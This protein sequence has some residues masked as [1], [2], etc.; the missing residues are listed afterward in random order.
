MKSF[1][2]SFLLQLRRPSDATKSMFCTGFVHSIIVTKY[3]LETLGL[4]Q[5]VFTRR[6]SANNVIEAFKHLQTHDCRSST[7]PC[8]DVVWLFSI[9]DRVV[10]I[11][12]FILKWYAVFPWHGPVPTPWNRF[13]EN[14]QFWLPWSSVKS[15]FG[16]DLVILI[17]SCLSYQFSQKLEIF[18][19]AFFFSLAKFCFEA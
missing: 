13:S 17:I 8:D 3:E 12:L 2:S 6:T 10:G 11:I 15:Y 1:R 7:G 9:W 4:S 18:K 14:M 19:S 5:V 16:L